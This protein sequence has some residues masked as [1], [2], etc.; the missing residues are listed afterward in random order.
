MANEM[1]KSTRRYEDDTKIMEITLTRG[2]YEDDNRL[3]GHLISADTKVYEEYRVVMTNKNAGATMETTGKP[4]D[5]AFFEVIAGNRYYKN[6]P[7]G[8]YARIGDAYIG[9][10]AYE[11]AAK[12]IAE[13][14]AEISDA[15]IA[16]IKAATQAKEEQQKELAAIENEKIV[17]EEE[18]RRKHPGWCEKCGSYCYGD[19][20]ANTD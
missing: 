1:K 7:A 12:M 11:I 17:E 14:D 8:A 9:Q 3:D 18:A 16:T 15:T 19:C 2:T 13:L 4:G 6:A 20:S 10:E 5:F